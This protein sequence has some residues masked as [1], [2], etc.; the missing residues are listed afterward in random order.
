M[1]SAIMYRLRDDL[2]MTVSCR[3]QMECIW[4]AWLLKPL[5]LYQTYWWSWP[6]RDET[7][8]HLWYSRFRRKYSL[9]KQPYWQ[10]VYHPHV[11]LP[12]TTRSVL[13]MIRTLNLPRTTKSKLIPLLKGNCSFQDQ[14]KR[15]LFL[16][17]FILFYGTAH[18]L[19]L[20]ITLPW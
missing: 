3:P 11:F 5:Q 16:V 12:N 9:A 6:R 8:D 2:P 4:R 14:H 18:M 19:H 1:A 15:R 7:I 17:I 13:S 10:A 20:L